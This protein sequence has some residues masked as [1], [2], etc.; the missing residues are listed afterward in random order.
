MKKRR[1]E[2]ILISRVTKFVFQ[3]TVTLF[4]WISAKDLETD[5]CRKTEN[6][7]WKMN[8]VKWNVCFYLLR[9]LD[10]NLS[11]SKLND[12]QFSSLIDCERLQTIWG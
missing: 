9:I 2:R 10:T 12:F 5:R 3:L 4:Y 11:E 7:Y 6:S 8:K 1:T